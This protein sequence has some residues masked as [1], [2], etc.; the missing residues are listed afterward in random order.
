M[1]KWIWV[2]IGVTVA[3]AATITGIVIY[4]NKK[5]NEL[6]AGDQS[7]LEQAVA[8]MANQAAAQTST[9]PTSG[10]G[11]PSQADTDMASAIKLITTMLG[12]ANSNNIIR[13]Q[14]TAVATQRGMRL[15]DLQ[16]EQAYKLGR[17]PATV[18]KAALK[19]KF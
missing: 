12:V 16:I 15:V 17:I 3:A 13:T 19:A 8:D 10:V 11:Q 5:K 6:A 14:L 7:S 18:D 9:A 4:K 1:N 2:G